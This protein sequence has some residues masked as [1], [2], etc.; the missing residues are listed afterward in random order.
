MNHAF[1]R[2]I[3]LPFVNTL[4]LSMRILPL[5]RTGDK[6]KMQ[7]KGGGWKPSPFLHD[8]CGGAY[9]ALARTLPSLM[10]FST[11]SFEIE[12]GTASYCLKIIVKVPRPCVTVR[13]A[14]E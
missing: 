9:S 5:H 6:G 3:Y 8:A 14:F 13:I 11:T 10:R 1:R 12:A 7:K 2:D 4:C